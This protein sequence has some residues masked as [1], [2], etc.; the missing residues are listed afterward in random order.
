[1]EIISLNHVD[2]NLK[3]RFLIKSV[4]YIVPS[5]STT[6]I[7]MVP[8]GLFCSFSAENWGVPLALF[9]IDLF[10]ATNRQF[11]VLNR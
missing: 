5:L 8:K 2:I 4:Y 1:M 10:N 9:S 3:S 11:F 6:L 7:G